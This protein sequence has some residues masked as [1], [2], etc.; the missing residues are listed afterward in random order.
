MFPKSFRLFLYCALNF[1]DKGEKMRKNSL[2]SLVFAGVLAG[3]VATNALAKEL[4]IAGSSTV[5][6]FT[7]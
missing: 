7:S 1:Y 5:Y 2:Q 4:T 6:P 3:F